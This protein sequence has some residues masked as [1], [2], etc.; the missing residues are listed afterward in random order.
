MDPEL[1]KDLDVPEDEVVDADALP[2]ADEAEGGVAEPD[3]D[4]VVEEEIKRALVPEEV[5]TDGEVPKAKTHQ[6]PQSLIDR[7]LTTDDLFDEGSI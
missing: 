6:I 4:P 5:D 2:I 1:E 7:D 3:I